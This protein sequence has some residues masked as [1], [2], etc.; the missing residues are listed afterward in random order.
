MLFGVE[1]ELWPTAAKLVG[2]WYI[3]G[4]LEAAKRCTVRW[5]ADKME[6]RRQWP[7]SVM[8][9]THGNG[10]EAGGGV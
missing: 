4:V 2:K 6:N 7:A 8:G 3:G 9:G 10:E 5:H 1:T